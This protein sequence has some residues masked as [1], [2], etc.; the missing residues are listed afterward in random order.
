MLTGQTWDS[1]VAFPGQSL[2]GTREEGDQEERE[3]EL[4]PR[5]AIARLQRRRYQRSVTGIGYRLTELG[6]QW[7]T[8][9]SRVRNILE[10]YALANLVVGA[11]GISEHHSAMFSG[12]WPDIPGILFDRTPFV[13]AY[14]SWKH[15]RL[16]SQCFPE[17][18]S[19]IFFRSFF[20]FLLG[21]PPPVLTFTSDSTLFLFAIVYCGSTRRFIDHSLS[22]T[23]LSSSWIDLPGIDLLRSI[24]NA[25]TIIQSTI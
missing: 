24:H 17:L 18:I 11:S 23:V 10:H 25:I 14:P 2:S 9:G 21:V 19:R 22:W 6:R 3:N 16:F 8:P 13:L 20:F 1:S 4:L 5:D 15:G 12:D 7:L